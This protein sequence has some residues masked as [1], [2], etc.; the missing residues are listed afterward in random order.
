MKK[1]PFIGL[2]LI[3]AVGI[4]VVCQAADRTAILAKISPEE[5]VKIGE[6]IYQTP[7]QQTCQKC[8]MGNG[9]GEGWAGAADLR[10]PY[11]WN[12]FTGLGG[13]E[14]LAAEPEKMR[15]EMRTVLEYLINEGG[16]KFNVQFKKAHPEIVI[17]WT[18]SVTKN[19]REYDMMMWGAVQTDHKKK[20]KKVQADLKA[21]GIELTDAE[22]RDLAVHSLIEYVKTFEEPHQ[23]PD[24]T[25]APKILENL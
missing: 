5:V 2:S 11:K 23:L 18:K 19:K 22:M 7:G 21:K 12:V 13:Y 24:G 14:R 9:Q 3:A 20:I 6:D 10:K 16:L 1:Y 4:A 17:D 8:H 15:A 25:D